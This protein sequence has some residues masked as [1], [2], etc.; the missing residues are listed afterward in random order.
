MIKKIAHLGIA[1]K[2]LDEAKN[3]YAGMLGLESVGE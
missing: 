1:V 2:N 3:F